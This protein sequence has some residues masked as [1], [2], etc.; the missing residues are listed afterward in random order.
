[1]FVVAV[2]TGVVVCSPFELVPVLMETKV[3]LVVTTVV[4]VVVLGF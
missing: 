2:V 4:I 1:V 3:P